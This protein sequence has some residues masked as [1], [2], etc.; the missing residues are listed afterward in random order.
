MKI[1]LLNPSYKI[2]IDKYHERYFV[3]SGS[4]WP[5]SLEK[6][7]NEKPPYIPYPFYLGY[8][9][10][11]L[12]E[13]GY[14]VSALDGVAL[15]LNE[16]QLLERILS[17]NADILLMET[18]TLTFHY[19]IKL[20][21]EIKKTN[22]DTIIVMAGTHVSAF[23]FES[24]KFDC[25][26]YIISGEYEIA[27][28]ELVERINN[29]KPLNNLNGVSYRKNGNVVY[30]GYSDLIFPLDLLPPPNR[31][32][33]PDNEF[34]DI[35]VYWDGFCQYKPAIQI[36]ASRG[37]PFRCYF[38]LW[39]QIMYRNGKYRTFSLERIISEIEY[40]IKEFHPK[41]IYFDDD[42]FTVRKDYVINICNE[43]IKRKIKIKWSCMGNI[44]NLDDEMID[45]MKKAGCIGIKFGVESANK[46]ILKNLGKP[47]ELD[48]VKYRV[49]LLN[50]NG[51][52]TH[53]TF[54]FGLLDETKES[55]LQTLSFAKKLDT[56]TVQFSISTP[57]PST[58]FFNMLSEK[59][60]LK[61][62]TYEDFNGGCK[63]VVKYPNLD[64]VEI[65]NFFRTVYKKWL[66]AKLTN[67][68][69]VFRWLKKLFN[70]IIVVGG[71]SRVFL[72]KTISRVLSHWLIK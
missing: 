6:K 3:R 65:E 55:M 32:I 22:R 34:P 51:I 17:K 44:M 1:L 68:K 25:I 49:D 63:A 58:R 15:D 14:N 39:N 72:L 4:R 36:H 71:E 60:Y 59:G 52:K 62:S 2:Q 21:N 66:I 11:L 46:D 27:F 13:K 61:Y 48:K 29:A 35:N 42:D 12:I 16:Y 26:D 69:W 7:I 53:A 43:I 28:T 30:G 41:E 31:K 38:C 8:T 23:P 57:Y 18:T 33:F 67:F 50:K 9:S 37:C 40:I 20:A 5:F 54:T 56:D 45:Y 19:D 10:S 47:M 70:T 24:I 64:S